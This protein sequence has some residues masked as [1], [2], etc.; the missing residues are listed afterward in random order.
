MPNRASV[1]GSGVFV[2]TWAP[3]AHAVTTP[4]CPHDDGKLDVKHL[5]KCP[6]AHESEE[7]L[8][9][10]VMLLVQDVEKFSSASINGFEQL[11][12]TPIQPHVPEALCTTNVRLLRRSVDPWDESSPQVSMRL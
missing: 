8:V 10:P 1:P 12:P 3:P 5:E 7:K 11:V 4:V 9:A 2:V 6:I